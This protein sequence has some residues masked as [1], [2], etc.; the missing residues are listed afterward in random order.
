MQLSRLDTHTCSKHSLASTPI[1]HN[2]PALQTCLFSSP[3]AFP[4]HNAPWAQWEPSCRCRMV[5]CST[6]HTELRGAA[7]PPE[8]NVLHW[9][10]GALPQN[11]VTYFRLS[12]ERMQQP[13]A[14]SGKD[15]FL[16]T[17]EMKWQQIAAGFLQSGLNAHLFRWTRWA[18]Q[19]CS[20]KRAAAPTHSI[21]PGEARGWYPKAVLFPAAGISSK[22]TRNKRAALKASAEHTLLHTPAS[23]VHPRNTLEGCAPRKLKSDLKRQHSE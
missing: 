21:N 9:N 11:A 7:V 3:S 19:G 8:L 12:S 16:C 18:S 17:K 4:A 5:L 14:G 20:A 2:L 6:V 23:R 10:C 13:Q 22:K 1:L 15:F